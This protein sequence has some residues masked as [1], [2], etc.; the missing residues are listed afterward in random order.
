MQGRVEDDPNNP[1]NFINDVHGGVGGWTG[2]KED[3]LIN[4]FQNEGYLLSPGTRGC[5]RDQEGRGRWLGEGERS[6]EAV[7]VELE[8]RGWQRAMG[9]A[10]WCMRRGGGDKKM[11]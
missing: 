4:G 3:V 8:V 1:S 11:M 10:P 5:G 9:K 2:N 6:R 7:E